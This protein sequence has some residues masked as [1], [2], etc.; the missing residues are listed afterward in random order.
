MG[1]VGMI[2][3]VVTACAGGSDGP[4]IVQAPTAPIDAGA[5]PTTDASVSSDGTSAPDA[6]REEDGWSSGGLGLVGPSAPKLCGCKLC[7]PIVSA[8]TCSADADCAPEVP[9]HAARCV[10]KAH[11]TARKPGQMCTEIMMCGT[12][13]ANACGC[14]KGKCTL[15]AR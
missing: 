12:A 11:A 2:V 8:D 3:G 10:A 15:H 5:P 14:V 9:C 13:D 4:G 7:D 1:F 6:S